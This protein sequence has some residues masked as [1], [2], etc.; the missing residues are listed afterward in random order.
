MGETELIDAIQLGISGVSPRFGRFLHCRA[1]ITRNRNPIPAM[2]QLTPVAASLPGSLAAPAMSTTRTLTIVSP[3]THPNAN[4]GPLPRALGPSRTR[5]TATIGMGLSATATAAGNSSPIA[6]LST[7]GFS[8]LRH[9]R[10]EI[11]NFAIARVGLLRGP[12]HNFR[13]VLDLGAPNARTERRQ[14]SAPTRARSARLE[15]AALNKKISRTSRVSIL[16][17]VDPKGRGSR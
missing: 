5:T 13:S 6:S 1:A 2:N 11:T 12:A 4:A 3:A 14:T 7:A 17:R 9:S 15:L 10:E 16:S 8:Q